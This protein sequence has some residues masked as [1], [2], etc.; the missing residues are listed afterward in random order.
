MVRDGAMEEDLKT[1]LER[2]RRGD[3]L[4]WESLVRR[5]QGRIHGIAIFY[6]GN[7]EE[8]RDLAQ[9]VFI[10]LYRRLDTCTNDETFVPWIIQ[11]TRNAAIDRLRRIKARRGGNAVPIDDIYD[12]RS[13]DPDPDETWRRN[14][15]RALVHRALDRLSHINR[16]IVILKEIQGLALDRIAS[17]LDLPLGTIKSRS[18]RARIE[19]AREVIALQGEEGTGP[20]AGRGIEP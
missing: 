16:E 4:A 2:C 11:I 10:R 5:F 17:M 9:E 6:L 18:H 3:D 19:L 20:I 14:R 15:R 8:A 1:L 12:L 7:A 13:T